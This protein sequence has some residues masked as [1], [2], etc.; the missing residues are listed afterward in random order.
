MEE[1]IIIIGAGRTGCEAVGAFAESNPGKKSI[2]PMFFGT[3][4]AALDELAENEVSQKNIFRMTS[5]NTFGQIVRDLGE[6]ISD[7]FSCTYEN[8]YGGQRAMEHGSGFS[9]LKAMISFVDFISRGGDKTIE[10]RIS[11]VV[12]DE[13]EYKVYTVAAPSDATGGELFLPITLYIARA[14]WQKGVHAEYGL[15]LSSPTAL[16]SGGMNEMQMTKVFGNAYASLREL[17]AVMSGAGGEEFLVGS[18]NDPYIGQLYPM[19]GEYSENKGLFSHV[20]V[21]GKIPGVFT[22]SGYISVISDMLFFLTS[23]I[24]QRTLSARNDN[25]FTFLSSASIDFPAG[26]AIDYIV[27]R[28]VCD[29]ILQSMSAC[30]SLSAYAEEMLGSEEKKAPRED[31]NISESLF[32][33]FENENVISDYINALIKATEFTDDAPVFDTECAILTEGGLC[34]RLFDGKSKITDKTDKFNS[35]VTDCKKE[36][37][38]YAEA[39]RLHAVSVGRLLTEKVFLADSDGELSFASAIGI[40]SCRLDVVFARL[41]TFRKV[42]AKVIDDKK[43]NLIKM[44]T[45]E[46]IGEYT[47]RATSERMPIIRTVGEYLLT[48]EKNITKEKCE[49]LASVLKRAGDDIRTMANLL[50]RYAVLELLSDFTD[51]LISEGKQ[52]ISDFK[53]VISDYGASGA[54]REELTELESRCEDIYKEIRGTLAETVAGRIS[55]V[56]VSVIS[57]IYGSALGINDGTPEREPAYKIYCG[58]K[59]RAVKAAAEGNVMRILR[60]KSVM[61]LMPQKTENDFGVY[62]SSIAD[63]AMPVFSYSENRACESRPRRGVVTVMPREAAEAIAAKEDGDAPKSAE[64]A[65]R[66]YLVRHKCLDSEFAICDGMSAFRIICFGFA[67]NLSLENFTLVRESDKNAEWYEEYL[68]CL[69]NE[70]KFRSVLW[71]PY[72]SSCTRGIPPC[73]DKEF[74]KSRNAQIC[75]ALVYMFIG[76]VFSA[77][78]DEKTGK[79]VVF[80]DEGGRKHPLSVD[81]KSIAAGDF[82]GMT[83]YLVSNE[84]IARDMAL[85]FDKYIGHNCAETV[86]NISGSDENDNLIDCTFMRALRGNSE[87]AEEKLPLSEMLLEYLSAGGKR[88]E[89]IADVLLCAIEKLCLSV[90]KESD[91]EI[92][93]AR[94]FKEIEALRGCVA[95]SALSRMTETA[96]EKYRSAV[97]TEE[98]NSSEER[99]C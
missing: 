93:G 58:E 73:I 19:Q 51:R 98:T 30:V 14:L 82:C 90:N 52:L 87:R 68:K 99:L 47:D 74:E 3:D 92:L 60:R 49:S 12:R 66:D 35:I 85:A 76:N 59:E 26:M 84:S 86:K 62:L 32:A 9:R 44:K 27:D 70:S 89:G 54:D 67:E 79:K 46:S 88:A 22:A 34:R 37:S 28:A 77:E 10:E 80:R 95:A 29:D 4:A 8:C 45:G 11:E 57:E 83:D 1:R 17:N 36:L 38:S 48:T 91:S 33:I 97:P 50:M 20:Y 94:I 23:D 39:F 56:T 18:G 96:E 21:V 69:E 25:A 63:R 72:I 15:L 41:C 40:G 75:K 81:G 53:E 5:K 16:M 13:A 65:V 7:W 42:L 6:G 43:C 31:Q 55:D 61:E 24:A 78:Y 64:D 2:F 71:H